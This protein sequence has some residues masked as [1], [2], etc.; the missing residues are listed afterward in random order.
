MYKVI[1]VYLIRDVQAWGKLL[2]SAQEL[3]G[4]FTSLR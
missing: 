2:C 4:Y 1:S 3:L